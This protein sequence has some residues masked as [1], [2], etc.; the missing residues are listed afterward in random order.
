MASRSLDD[1]EPETQAK[2]RV[3]VDACGSRGV[4]VLVYCTLRT[5]A[6][7]AALYEIGRSLPGRI[8]TR[9]PAWQSWH[10][11]GRAVDAV[12]L[13]AGKPDWAMRFTKLWDVMV[14]EGDR[15]G[16]EWAGRWKKFRESVHWQYTGEMSLTEAYVAM[17]NRPQEGVA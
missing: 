11:Y 13:Q 16:L 17:Q 8:V 14:E 10:Q 7:Q 4:D 6:E 12:P 9:A 2:V 5:A 3:W 1:L 15:L